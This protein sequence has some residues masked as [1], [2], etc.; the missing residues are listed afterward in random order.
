M[1]S[2]ED[3]S[4]VDSKTEEK[5]AQAAA[6]PVTKSEAEKVSKPAGAAPATKA[7]NG[8]P[9][10][11]TVSSTV[12]TVNT[13]TT[14][15]SAVNDNGARTESLKHESPELEKSVFAPAPETKPLHAD[16]PSFGPAPIPTPAPSP[17]LDA[18]TAPKGKA[19]E[20]VAA[21]VAA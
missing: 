14:A 5:V 7:E 6:Q 17:P 18:P 16:M 20:E 21:S 11:S 8:T 1:Y 9:A 10:A 19:A 3:E 15:D 12:N 13:A 2:T 4:A